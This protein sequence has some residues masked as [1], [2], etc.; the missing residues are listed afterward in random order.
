MAGLPKVLDIRDDLRRAEEATDA[1]IREEVEGVLGL[2]AEYAGDGPAESGN[3]DE[4]DE[5]L[6]RMEER[7]DS[8]VASE[9]FQAARNR[10]RLFRE[11]LSGADEGLVVLHTERTGGGVRSTVV[12]SADA[13]ATGTVTVA[14]YDGDGTELGTATA[15]GVSFDAGEERTLTV[16]TDVPAGT[17]RHVSRV[18]RTG[19]PE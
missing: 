19:T 13:A 10:I 16:A 17:E 11:S 5:R 1:D 2:L 6:L 4:A 9:R 7:T 12:N 18:E 14:F 3:L 15:E 8:D